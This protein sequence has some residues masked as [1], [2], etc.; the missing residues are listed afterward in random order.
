M[1]TRPNRTQA[2]LKRDLDLWHDEEA[3]LQIETIAAACAL[4]AYADGI[5]R[6]AEHDSMAASLS[7]FG[8]VDDRSRM[9]L[10]AEFEH[11]TARFEIDPSTG[12]RAALTTIGRLQGKSRFTQALIET[13]RLIGEAD[14]HYIVEEQSALVKICRQLGVDP[15]AAGAF[16]VPERV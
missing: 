14:G 5:V 10:L 13:C 2:D 9:E 1:P 12:E 7:R 6:P 11:V 4:I 16:S 8:L 15:V 3:S